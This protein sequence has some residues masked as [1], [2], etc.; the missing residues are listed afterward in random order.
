MD[1]DLIEALEGPAPVIVHLVTVELPDTTLR[2]TYEGGFVVWGANTYQFSDAAY[3]VLGR[4]SEMEDGVTGNATP[5]DL[6]ILC[7]TEA[8]ADLIAPDVQGSLVTVHLGA[9]DRATGLLVGEPELL[10]RAELDQPNIA[11]GPSLGLDFQCITEEARC[12]EPNEEQRLTSAFHKSVW[13]GEL[14]YD[15]VTDLEQKV[16]WR[17]D[18]PTNAVVRTGPLGRIVAAAAG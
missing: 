12:L 9:V 3:G 15:F 14:G 5:L 4:L 1:E 10:F 6:S 2:W 8:M 7:D 13:P 17:M 18:D 16:Y 11:A